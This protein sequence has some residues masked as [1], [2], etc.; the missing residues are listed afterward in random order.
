MVE[1]AVKREF[2]SK[3]P[4]HP[5]NDVLNRDA[6]TYGG[7]MK[8]DVATAV[9]YTILFEDQIYYQR[10]SLDFNPSLIT[11]RTHDRPHDE[12]GREFTD[13]DAEGLHFLQQE[14]FQ[15]QNWI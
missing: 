5:L 8:I 6:I 10:N 11:V 13:A 3:Y 4:N 12:I 9:R 7:V 2:A 1:L 14:I 15:L